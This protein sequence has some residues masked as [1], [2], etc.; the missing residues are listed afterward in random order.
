[1]S[2]N[3]IHS[4]TGVFVVATLLAVP[5]GLSASGSGSGGSM[6]APRVER[7]PLTPEQEAV[8]IYND[9]ISYREKAT[10]LEKEAD[11]EA[12]ARKKEKLLAKARDKHQDSIKKFQQATKKSPG[13]FQAWGSLGYAYRKTG[14]YTASLEAYARALEIQPNY[15]PAIEYRAEAYLGLNQLDE[16]QSAYI[17]LFNRDRARADEL[18]A[19]IDKWLEKKKTDPAGV[20]PARL[21]EFSRWAEQRKHLAS[22]TSSVIQPKNERW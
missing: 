16:V 22:Q 7:Q 21:E 4:A 17:L 9:G 13:M 20:D 19:A 11:A 10:K 18:A 15:T 12:D 6:P 1:M 3:R 2:N 5:A 14:D 8:E